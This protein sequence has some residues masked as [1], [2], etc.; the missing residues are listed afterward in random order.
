MNSVY[1]VLTQAVNKA[2]DEFVVR[3]VDEPLPGF[4]K[5]DLNVESFVKFHPK[6]IGLRDALA[7]A[8]CYILRYIPSYLAPQ[9]HLISC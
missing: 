6:Q 5:S 2:P 9:N 4:L 8:C 1:L 3:A 7:I